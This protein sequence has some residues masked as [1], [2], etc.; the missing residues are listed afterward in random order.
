MFLGQRAGTYFILAKVIK[1]F[2]VL[3]EHINLSEVWGDNVD[4][5]NV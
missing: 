2:Y 5:H 1:T 4:L 3:P